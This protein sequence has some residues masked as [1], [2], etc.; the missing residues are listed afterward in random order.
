MSTAA[1][2]EQYTPTH[3]SPFP[4]I[5]AGGGGS[6]S[7]VADAMVGA[8][9]DFVKKKRPIYISSEN[10]DLPKGNVKW[11]SQQH[12]EGAG[13]QWR[14]KALKVLNSTTLTS[15]HQTSLFSPALVRAVTR[16]CHFIFWIGEDKPSTET[17]FLQK[18]EFEDAV[19]ELCSENKKVNIQLNSSM[20]RFDY[21]EFNTHNHKPPWTLV[22][23]LPVRQEVW[24]SCDSAATWG[25]R[26][27][28]IN[29]TY[30]TSFQMARLLRTHQ[31][32]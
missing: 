30:C 24:D 25:R 19:F 8:I 23:L 15:S 31:R 29:R 17:L 11:L 1:S 7:T 13:R 6:P 20:S 27:K 28:S 12:D 18:E 3:L 21:E 32:T 16:C 26:N 22:G 14:A 2:R 10:R 4:S 5:R 9:T